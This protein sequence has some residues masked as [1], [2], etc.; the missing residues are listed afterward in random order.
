MNEYLKHQKGISDTLN[1]ME[2]TQSADDNRVAGKEY[3]NRNINWKTRSNVSSEDLLSKRIY[4][5]LYE[6]L[7][8]ETGARPRIS[9]IGSTPTFLYFFNRFAF[10]HCL[11]STHHLYIA[12]FRDK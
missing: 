2:G 1:A 10:Q 8:I 11:R 9:Y 12:L 6:G 4:V 7:S 3:K 5:S